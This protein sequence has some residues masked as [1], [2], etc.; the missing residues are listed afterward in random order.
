MKQ[1]AIAT[2]IILISLLMITACSESESINGEVVE[3]TNNANNS[4][5]QNE[6]NNQSNAED[7][8]VC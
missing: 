6:N 3:N 5:D 7:E 2:V 8:D 4:N 1:F